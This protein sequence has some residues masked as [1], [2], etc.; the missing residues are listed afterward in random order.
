MHVYLT[1]DLF[2]LKCIH[3]HNSY[4]SGRQ[5]RRRGGKALV[6]GLQI[7]CTTHRLV[8][9]KELQK[10]HAARGRAVPLRGRCVQCF[11]YAPTPSSGGRKVKMCDGSYIPTTRFAC[12]VCRVLL[13]NDCF[14]N[15]Y[16]HRKR[17]VPVDTLTLR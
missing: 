15:V 7:G 13:C 11:A 3:T 4:R 10:G 9:T 12:A 5:L 14:W 16:D 2:T 8:S 6:D 17:G 1:L